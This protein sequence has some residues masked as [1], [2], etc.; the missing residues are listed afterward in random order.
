[1]KSVS[2]KRLA[3][4]LEEHGWH[5]IR[6]HGSHHIFCKPGSVVRLSVPI[7]ANKPLKVGLLKHLL[8]IAELPED[9]L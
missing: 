7:H 8:K 3:K 4:L 5:L 9:T 6:T 2:G 1:M